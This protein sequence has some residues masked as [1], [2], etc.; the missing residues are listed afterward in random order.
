[1]AVEEITAN[2]VV[3]LDDLKE[4]AGA[5][6]P[7]I[8][9]VIHVPTPFEHGARMKNAVRLLEERLVQRGASS[10][11]IDSLLEPVRNFARST[12]NAGA[13]SNALILF[14]SPGVFRYFVLHRPGPDVVS[15]DDRFQIRPLLPALAREQRFHLLC[16]SRRHIRLLEGN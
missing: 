6:G 7:C 10:A 3:T 11:V 5:A 1:M 13:W 9:V 2:D 8:T 16:L 14:R 15:V 4:L 12:G